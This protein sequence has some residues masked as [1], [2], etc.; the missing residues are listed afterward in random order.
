MIHEL[1]LFGPVS[2]YFYTHYGIAGP[3]WGWFELNAYRKS[4]ITSTVVT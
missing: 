4:Y 3:L 1:R 2:E